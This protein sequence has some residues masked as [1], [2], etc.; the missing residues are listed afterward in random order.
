MTTPGTAPGTTA[1]FPVEIELGLTHARVTDPG[2][3]R[4][5]GFPFHAPCWEIL[6]AARPSARD[7][8]QAIFDVC[9]ST[10]I[11]WG[12][13]QFG[14][15]YG[16]I[17]E[18]ETKPELEFYGEASS[19]LPRG[20]RSLHFSESMLEPSEIPELRWPL[21]HGASNVRSRPMGLLRHGQSCCGCFS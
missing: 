21:M 12:L 5:R 3:P 16:G 2:S 1:P 8:V 10:P 6:A 20:R 9:R 18:L 11:D 7:D 14:H 13:M 15:D 4:F 19:Y 17:V